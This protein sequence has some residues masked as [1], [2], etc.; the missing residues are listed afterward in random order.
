MAGDHTYN[1]LQKVCRN[2]GTT[3]RVLKEGTPWV[4]KAEFDIGLKNEAVRKFMNQY[5]CTIAFWSYCVERHARINNMTA[6]NLFQ[7]HISN[8]YT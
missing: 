7:L 8:V 1:D 5:D 2:I 4:N 6:K 3:L